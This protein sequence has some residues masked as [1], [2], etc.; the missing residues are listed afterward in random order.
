MCFTSTINFVG[1]ADVF[2]SATPLNSVAIAMP[3]R[4]IPNPYKFYAAK[5]AI[6][7]AVGVIVTRYR[8]AVDEFG[9]D[10]YILTKRIETFCK[11]FPTDSSYTT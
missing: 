10:T 6:V 9:N 2:A 5:L 8:I 4:K 3:V 7:G 1:N 11:F